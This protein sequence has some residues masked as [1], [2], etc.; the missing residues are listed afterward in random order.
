MKRTNTNTK[1]KKN[2]FAFIAAIL[3]FVAGSATLIRGVCDIE[4]GTRIHEARSGYMNMKNDA[5]VS[6]GTINSRSTV[7]T[8]YDGYKDLKVET[9]TLGK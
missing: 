6:Q 1:A 4:R 7:V 5:V 8:N 2:R 3:L 9:L